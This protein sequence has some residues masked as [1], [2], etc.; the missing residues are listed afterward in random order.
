MSSWIDVIVSSLS[1][2]GIDGTAFGIAIK[3]E[4][5]VEKSHCFVNLIIIISEAKEKNSNEDLRVS[6]YTFATN[7]IIVKM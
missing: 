7:R 2:E 5:K 3:V 4:A 1:E 6:R